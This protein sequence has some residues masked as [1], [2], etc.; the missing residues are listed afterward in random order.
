MSRKGRALYQGSSSDRVTNV[1]LRAFAAEVSEL[2][3]GVGAKMTERSLGLLVDLV[4][5][6]TL[7][8]LRFSDSMLMG[9]DLEQIKS[10][11]LNQSKKLNFRD[12]VYLGVEGC[13]LVRVL[14]GRTRVKM[15]TLRDCN[16]IAP[17]L[18]HLFEGLMH[19]EGNEISELNLR[20]NCI[21]EA[22]LRMLK[23]LLVVKRVKKLN[24]SHCYISSYQLD[25]IVD[26]LHGMEG[27]M[28]HLNLGGNMIARKDID[29]FKLRTN[30]KVIEVEFY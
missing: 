7:T 15:I 23:N 21:G 11:L 28:E 22:G 16:L 14:L 20:G 6:K 17:K 1:I 25:Y 24:L 9:D 13:S 5:C 12:K 18:I 2:D 27:F 4:K 26:G 29:D 10:L 30:D 3:L 8:S 19:M